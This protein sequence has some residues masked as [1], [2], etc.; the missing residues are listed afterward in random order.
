MCISKQQKTAVN[1]RERGMLGEG[2]PSII[3]G[4]ST[5]ERQAG[6]A[7]GVAKRRSL[8]F[9]SIL[10]AQEVKVLTGQLK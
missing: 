2:Q 5:G 4:E 1:N 7:E 9:T 3:C 6:A 8:L 10:S